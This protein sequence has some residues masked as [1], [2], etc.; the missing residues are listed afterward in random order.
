MFRK[1][2]SVMTAISL[3]AL[4]ALGESQRN[5]AAAQTLNS[6]LLTPRVFLDI[7]DMQLLTGNSMRIAWI[8][9]RTGVV[10]IDKYTITL[11]LNRNGKTER[12]VTTA[13]GA[14]TSATVDLRGI[15]A[16]SL[17][18]L[19][20]PNLKVTA[21]LKADFTGRTSSGLVKSVTEVKESKTFTS[22]PK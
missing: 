17:T 13:A 3:L 2:I 1:I 21:T 5:S 22:I 12:V 8:A 4:L 16:D 6:T 20:G 19:L 11:V 18:T 14:S 15:S 7:T 10:T 9:Q